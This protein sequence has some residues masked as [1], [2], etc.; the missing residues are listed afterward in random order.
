MPEM[1]VIEHRLLDEHTFLL[2]DQAH[3]RSS[4]WR[5]MPGIS[6]A[7]TVLEKEAAALPRLVAVDQLDQAQRVQAL[8]DLLS[9][10]V[11]TPRPVAALMVSDGGIDRLAKHL[12]ARLV[13]SIPLQGKHLFRY[14]DPRVFRHLLWM[15]TPA[16][17]AALFG[18][19]SAWT[20]CD[21]QGHWH[22][23]LP[24]QGIEPALS[25]HPMGLDLAR[26]GLLERCLKVL[27]NTVPDYTDDAGDVQPRH[28]NALLDVALA[29]GLIDEADLHLYVVQ[30]VRF[31]PRIH[32]HPNLVRRLQAASTDDSYV[33]ACSDLDADT[34]TRYARELSSPCKDHA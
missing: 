21:H 15:A 29:H 19:V 28:A 25:F 16:Q 4:F 33:G 7:P 11:E 30:A 24:P 23:S 26:I 32:S 17:L 3:A 22:R 9:A 18:P 34:L 31:H 5:G 10:P 2:L 1:Q 27:R 14:Y 8:D 6:I 13:V 20:W 12:S